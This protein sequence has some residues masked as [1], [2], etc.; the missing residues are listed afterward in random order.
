MPLRQYEKRD[1]EMEMG[2]AHNTATA[3]FGTA[4]R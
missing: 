2:P 3:L 4:A 1:P